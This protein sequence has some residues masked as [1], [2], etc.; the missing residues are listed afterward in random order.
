MLYRLLKDLLT[1]TNEVLAYEGKI[2]NADVD[3]DALLAKYGW[4]LE[5]AGGDS[6]R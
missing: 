6:I 3:L 5:D 1:A 2:P 4:M